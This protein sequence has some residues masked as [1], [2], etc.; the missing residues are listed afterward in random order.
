MRFSRRFD[1][2]PLG[3]LLWVMLA[4]L[5]RHFSPPP[6]LARHLFN[7]Y[8]PFMGAGI[9]I[10]RIDSQFL[11]IR[12]E[13]PLTKLNSNYVGTQFGGSMYA[14]TD[15]FYMLM[16]IQNLGPEFIVWD[17]AARIEF[18]KPGRKRV[19]AEFKISEPEVEE[20]RA[21]AVADGKYIF[22]REV[23]ILDTDGVLVAR[24]TKT[25]Y[26][27]HKDLASKA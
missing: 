11:F 10:T 27:R 25:L 19:I 18:L 7:L 16:L 14:M 3:K 5:L 1:N 20:I 15:P 9:R 6:N 24:V 2:M 13:M 12:V 21:K 17:K 8:P 26:V 22:D 23:L 4:N